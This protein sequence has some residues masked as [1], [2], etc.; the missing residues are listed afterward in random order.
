LTGDSTRSVHGT[1]E[2]DKQTGSVTT[3]IYQTA[4]FAFTKAEEVARAARGESSSYVYS[5]WD[6]PTVKTLETKVADLEGAEDA[7]FFS[8]GMA[9]ISTAVI[10]LVQRGDHVLGIRDLYG[11]SY[12][13]IHDFLPRFGVES[14]LV[15]T[16]DYA[17]MKRE[18][19]SNTKIVYIESPTNPTIKVVDIAR[20]AAIAHEVGARL[21]IDST[22]AS[23]INQK[24]LKRGADLVLH[25]ATKYLNGHADVTAGVSAGPSDLIQKIKSTR[26]TLGG[27]LD[28]HAAY[29]IL[30]GIKTLALRVEKN[31]RNAQA[32]AEY[33]SK[34]EKVV[35]VNYPGLKTHPQHELAKEQM[36]GFGGVL[37]F[38]VRGGLEDAMRFTESLRLATL[39]ASLG[40]V[41]TLVSQPATLTHLQL[42]P[43]E[44]KK[45]GMPET[46]VRVAVGVEDAEDLI[47][48]FEQAF[49]RV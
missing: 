35:R 19:R 45:S 25:S 2:A 22:F 44:R 7:A 48:D 39:G 13:L 23:P 18:V 32:L 24:P 37:S 4:T 43:E 34:H 3:P 31:N 11:E 15:D 29:L 21:L 10:S 49:A 20:A 38:E 14:S 47:K 30:R 36:T 33:L 12:K 6:N 42:S 26:R 17:A 8:S 27:T 16:G 5:R 40:G 1:E 28:P 9:A 41:E 46:L